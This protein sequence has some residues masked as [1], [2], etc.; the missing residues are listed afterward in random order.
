[1]GAA[2]ERRAFEFRAV[3]DGSVLE[4]V[5][6]PFGAAGQVGRFTEEFRAGA[7][8]YDDVEVNVLHDPGR[9]LARTNGGGLTLTESATEL[10]ARVEL[11]DTTEG[12]DTMTLVRN[13]VLRGFSVEFVAKRDIW[14]G[15]HRVVEA[16]RL[17]GLAVVG[18][19]A[20]AG[21]VV[22]EGRQLQTVDWM[23]ALAKTGKVRKWRSL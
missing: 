5:A 11:P 23:E 18:R 6:M 12:R 16:A 21:A 20:Y 3:D 22:T 17:L 1:M 15:T 9:L 14:Q 13:G 8:S 7:L 4:G 10:R 2:I 19:P